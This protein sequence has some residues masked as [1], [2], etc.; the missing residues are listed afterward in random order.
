MD[1]E[2]QVQASLRDRPVSPG[3]LRALVID[4]SAFDRRH[5]ARLCAGLRIAVDGV[6][7]LTEAVERV[8]LARYDIVFAD[9]SLGA[10]TGFDVPALLDGSASADATR[11]LL[12]G[13]ED[14]RIAKEAAVGGFHHCLA[15]GRLTVESLAGLTGME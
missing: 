4:D 6:G 10:A 8:R 13:N 1:S 2:M 5:L 9:H 7:T 11:V 15:K 14:P 12:T 3:W